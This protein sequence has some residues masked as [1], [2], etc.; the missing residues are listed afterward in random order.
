MAME[1]ITTTDKDARDRMFDDLRKNGNK[2]E[3]QVMKFSGVEPVLDECG[4][5]QIFIGRTITEKE[6]KFY[7]NPHLIKST[8]PEL[9]KRLARNTRRKARPIWR[10]TWSVAYPATANPNPSPRRARRD[11]EHPYHE[12][13]IENLKE[14][15][16]A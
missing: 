16:L 6:M 4:I 8:P 11:R 9:L 3:K 12:T 15:V 5:Q 10:S 14:G 2:L 1:V 7:M 13:L